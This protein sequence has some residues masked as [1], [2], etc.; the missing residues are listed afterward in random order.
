MSRLAVLVLRHRVAVA[1]LWL[2]ALVAGVV[3]APAIIHRIDN[4]L[5]LRGEAGYDANAAI[6]ARYQTGF[7]PPVVAVVTLASGGTAERSLSELT[8][9]FD[10]AGR[11]LGTPVAWYGNTGDRRLV[12]AG[13]H[14]ALGLVLTP[15][16]RWLD[17]EDRSD[18]VADSM[19][20]QL[21]RGASVR[22]TGIAA[23]TNHGQRGSG[24][25]VGLTFTAGVLALIVLA[26][27]FGSLLALAP[28]LV[29]VVAIF[30]IFLALGALEQVASVNVFVEYLVALLGL[31]IAIDYSLLIVTRWREELNQGHAP[32]ESA[33][34]AI[35]IAG[36][37]VVLSGLTVAVGLL[38]MIVVPVGFVRAIGYST[39][40]IPL[41]SSMVAV[42]LLP[43]ILATAGPRLDWPHKRSDLAASRRWSAWGRGVIRWRWAALA[44]GVAPLSVLAVFAPELETGNPA[45]SALAKSGPGYET[46]AT[47][48]AEGVPTG[49]LSPVAVLLPARNGAISAAHRLAQI[50]GVWGALAPTGSAWH[51]RGTALAVV[52]PAADP[53]TTPGRAT[54]ARVRTRA[55][56]E[57][58]GAKVGGAAA[59]DT[60]FGHAIRGR[61][62]LML[63]VIA[64]LS[65]VLLL[66]T[67]R[68]LTL[69]LKAV[70][71]SLASI[72]AALGALVL[73]WQR[74][75]GSQAVWGIPATGAIVSFLPLLIVVFLFTLSIDYE[76]FLTTR[77]REEYDRTGST[78]TAVIEG[79]GRTGRLITSAALILFFAFAALTAAPATE[80]KELASALGLGIL[81]DATIV[82]ALLTPAL[83]AA[84]GN[85]TW[86]LPRWRVGTRRPQPAASASLTRSPQSLTPTPGP[87]P[88]PRTAPPDHAQRSRAGE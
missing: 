82:R 8:R 84:L 11:A 20:P 45:V 22:V 15:G 10:A 50:P 38:S 28:L 72:A 71:T 53:A 24:G 18:Q 31:G 87:Q 76:V 64:L 6:A 16:V 5:P 39:A 74:G 40:L 4:D 57:L 42:T 36:R 54:L 7:Q 55:P 1:G 19:R 52:L 66:R 65:F 68:S 34:R 80:I 13:G 21:P 59:L 63:G 85:R 14:A 56:G 43:V 51:Q 58:P 33:R 70:A 78:H 81:F 44:I 12:L 60:D 48:H 75:Y 73:I 30:G 29:A 32:E 67:F 27:V 49:V 3:L 26:F 62:P 61:L 41:I 25:L 86:W 37:T 17:A 35:A 2:V 9:A 77:M 69:A 23:L 46:L 88:T 47:L 79:T 83:I